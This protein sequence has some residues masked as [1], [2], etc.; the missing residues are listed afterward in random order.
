VCTEAV[1]VVRAVG[2]D[3]N[4][5][6]EELPWPILGTIPAFNCMY[7]YVSNIRKSRHSLDRG[8][9]PGPLYCIAGVTFC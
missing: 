9:N 5:K 2:A 8:S 6:C 1:A 7:E 4:G 3:G